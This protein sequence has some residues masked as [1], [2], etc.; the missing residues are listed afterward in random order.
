MNVSRA[1]SLRGTLRVPG[2]KS[3]SH[4]ALMLSSLASGES[5]IEGLSPGLD[6]AATA[7]IMG[8]LGATCSL[9]SDR[10]IVV[11]RSG[12]LRPS[13]EPLYCANSGTTMRLLAGLVSAIAGVHVL[14]GDESLSQRPM[15]RVAQPLKMMG[16]FVTGRGPRVMAPLRIEGSS[17]LRAIEYHVPMSSAQ[18]KSAVLLAGLGASGP[19]TVIEDVRTRSTTEDML[20]AANVRIDSVDEGNGRRVTVHPGRPTARHWAVP[21]DPSQAAFFVV[22]GLIH[23]DAVVEVQD[24]D[25]SPERT[26]FMTVLQRMGADLSWSGPGPTLSV[27]ASSSTLTSTEVFA[28]EV[29]S[30][31]EVPVLVVAAAAARGVSSFHRMGELRLKESDRFAGALALASSLGC[32]VWSEGDDFFIE[33]LG[34]AEAFAP[35]SMDAALDHRMVMSGAVAGCAGAGATIE[36]AETVR[37]SYP[38]FFD[39]LVG[40]S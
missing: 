38:H 22:L 6:V 21:G 12:G 3:A 36:G 13:D 34:S 23:P 37:T 17:S 30:V 11:G 20:S 26:G 14:D 9:E 25:G 19:T 29:P 4:R 18:V 40:L 15:D 1:R 2:D 24:L 39:D 7:R 31:D 28:D 5:R 32:R 33:G 27:V 8:Q 16:S 10:A 35:F